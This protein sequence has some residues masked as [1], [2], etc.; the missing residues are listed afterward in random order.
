M[1]LV[2]Q[3]LESIVI[4]KT[5]SQ[6]PSLPPKVH[7]SQHPC[8]LAKLSQL[9]SKSTSA[10]DVKSL[11]HEISLIVGCEALASALSTGSGAKVC[12]D[13]PPQPTS[14]ALFS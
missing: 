13:S 10:R 8:L 12:T 9:R 6:I 11:V 2:F 4:N 3:H 7:V 1:L 14:I 5:M